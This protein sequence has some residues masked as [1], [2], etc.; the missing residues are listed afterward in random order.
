M[1]PKKSHAEHCADLKQWL[2]DHHGILP[3]RGSGDKA[4]VSLGKWLSNTAT[5]RTCAQGPR[6]DQKQLTPQQLEQLD[7]AMSATVA[8]QL[9][10]AQERL[11]AKDAQLKTAHEELAAKEAQ[12]KTAR[13][14]VALKDAQLKTAREEHAAMDEGRKE[15]KR[16]IAELQ[17]AADERGVAD[18]NGVIK[19]RRQMIAVGV[20]VEDDSRKEL[21]WEIKTRKA[22]EHLIKKLKA[23]I[24]KLDPDSQSD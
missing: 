22:N 2:L 3:K 10:T 21:Q 18:K 9:K 1:A 20:Q 4:E 14:E 15:L 7:D 6:P 17:C 12:L 11:A 16:K 23:K 13:E 8:A 19:E 24:R 5:R